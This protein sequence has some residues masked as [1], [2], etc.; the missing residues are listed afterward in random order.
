M[1]KRNRTPNTHRKQLKDVFSCFIQ[2]Q[3]LEKKRQE[4]QRELSS[5]IAKKKVPCYTLNGQSNITT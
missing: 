2:K 4:R 3:L 1:N 5:L